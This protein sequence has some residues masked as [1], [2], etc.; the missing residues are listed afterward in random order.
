MEEINRIKVVLVEQKR[1]SLWL[2]KELCVST[3]T[4]SRWC[5]N[6]NQPDLYTIK[7][8]AQLLNVDPRELLTGSVT[9]NK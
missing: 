3:T 6:S 2:A 1:T 4:V 7:R 5:T 9:I 8:I